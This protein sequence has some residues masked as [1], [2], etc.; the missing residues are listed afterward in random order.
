[1][2]SVEKNKQYGVNFRKLDTSYPVVMQF[3][4]G[5]ILERSPTS[6]DKYNC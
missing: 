6:T 5:R 4:S 2:K 3:F 1:M